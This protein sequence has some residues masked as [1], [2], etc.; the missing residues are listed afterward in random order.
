MYQYIPDDCLQFYKTLT[1]SEDIIDDVDGF[2]G[3]PDFDVELD[4]I[5]DDIFDL[6]K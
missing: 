3:G 6:F 4:T 5:S 1:S 2:G